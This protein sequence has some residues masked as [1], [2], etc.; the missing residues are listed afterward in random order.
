MKENGFSRVP[1]YR[2][3]LDGCGNGVC[4][5]LQGGKGVAAEH[6]GGATGAP[7]GVRAGDEE[8]R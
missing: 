2:T 3:S 8:R 7:G 6:E 4:A 1:V 5:R